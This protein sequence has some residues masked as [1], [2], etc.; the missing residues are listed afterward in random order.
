[1][2]YSTEQLL[3]GSASYGS[4]TPLYIHT[5]QQVKDVDA[6]TPVSGYS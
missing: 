5:W 1:M 3:I 4:K 2:V 6:D